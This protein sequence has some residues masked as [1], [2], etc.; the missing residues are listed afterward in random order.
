MKVIHVCWR[1]FKRYRKHE[2][3][4]EKTYTLQNNIINILVTILL[5]ILIVLNLRVSI[6]SHQGD[7]IM[8]VVFNLLFPL[9]DTLCSSSP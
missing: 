1:K 4:S 5:D 9:K 3:E 8:C 7:Y 6:I 2:K